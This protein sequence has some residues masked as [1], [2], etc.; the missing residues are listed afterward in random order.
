MLFKWFAFTGMVIAQQTQNIF[1]IPV[2]C[3]TNVEVVVQ[4]SYERLVFAGRLLDFIIHRSSYYHGRD[5][6]LP[7]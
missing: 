1:I 3:W 2:Q 5:T 4:M 6:A 7:Q